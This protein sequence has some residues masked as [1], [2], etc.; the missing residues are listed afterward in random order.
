MKCPKCEAEVH[1]GDRFCKSCGL[2]LKD[3]TEAP[4]ATGEATPADRMRGAGPA[5]ANAE[6]QGPAPEKDLWEGRYS[7]LKGGGGWILSA[8]VLLVVVI[9]YLLNLLGLQENWFLIA[10]VCAAGLLFLWSFFRHLQAHLTRKYKVTSQRV[11]YIQGFL[12]R[13]TDEIEI[14]RVDDVQYR[15]T[16]VDR[17]FSLGTVVVI[18]PTDRTHGDQRGPDGKIA[19]VGTLEL[20]GVKNP[21]Q[22]KELIR[23]YC[24][25]RRDKGALF[26]EQV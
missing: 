4:A 5:G 24:R 25:L 11:F 21:E 8:V 16:L 2:E 22:V 7:I 1:L 13:T 26:V 3:E 19:Q 20:H 17:I 14:I 9:I 12:S 15:Q 18:A 6:A 23:S 10:G